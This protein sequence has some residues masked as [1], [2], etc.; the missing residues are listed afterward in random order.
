MLKLHPGRRG[1]HRRRRAGRALGR[2]DHRRRVARAGAQ[3]EP[4]TLIG[5][6]RERLAAFKA[7]KHVV[8]VDRVV[9]SPAGKADYRWALE[10][11]KARVSAMS[12]AREF[13]ASETTERFPSVIAGRLPQPENAPEARSSAVWGM[14]KTGKL[15]DPSVEDVAEVARAVGADLEYG[16]TSAEA[17]RRLARRRAERAPPG[18]ASYPSGGAIL[19]QFRDPLIYLLLARGRRVARRVGRSRTTR[20]GRSMRS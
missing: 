11:A 10:T 7:P 20:A 16:L 17:A 5:L 8:V 4:P 1:L 13:R 15:D 12:E 2:G 19:A 3:A 6:A 9:R 18:A 14:T